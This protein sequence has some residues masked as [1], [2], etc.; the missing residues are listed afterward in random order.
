M[1]R[2]VLVSYE[3]LTGLRVFRVWEP[4]LARGFHPSGDAHRLP[5]GTHRWD[6]VQVSGFR[7]QISGGSG[8]SASSALLP[9]QFLHPHRFSSPHS[10]HRA[11]AARSPTKIA[12][13]GWEF[14]NVTVGAGE[15]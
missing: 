2:G 13:R 12:K 9:P 3:G 5:K 14:K 1:L 8:P 10:A 11:L 4:G 15:F 7:V 6:L